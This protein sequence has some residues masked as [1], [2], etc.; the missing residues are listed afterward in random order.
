MLRHHPNPSTPGCERLPST[1]GKRWRV[2][3]A[4]VI[5]NE[6]LEWASSDGLSR[7]R[8]IGW[9]K[10]VLGK[11]SLDRAFGDAISASPFAR[12][13]VSKQVARLDRVTDRVRRDIEA[14]GHLADF[15]EMILVRE[16]VAA[17]AQDECSTSTVSVKA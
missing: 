3:T 12:Q 15:K 8:L 14:L 17:D 16:L 7:L 10:H 1:F 5:E 9:M 11:I 4:L 13:E 2:S 6:V